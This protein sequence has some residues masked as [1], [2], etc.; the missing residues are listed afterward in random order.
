[1]LTGE[2]NGLSQFL[3]DYPG[4]S[5]TPHCH[6]GIRLRGKF[7]FKATF[8]GYEEIEDTYKLEITVPEK[9]PRELPVV[10]EI[11]EK[12]PRDENK[13][14]HVNS[15]DTLCL[16]S[17]HR[18]LEKIYKSPNLS[19]FT[20]KCLIPYL[21]AVSYKLKHG[22]NFIF[23]ELSHGYSGII[24]DCSDLFGLT[25]HLQVKKCAINLMCL[26]DKNKKINKHKPRI[27]IKLNNGKA[28]YR[29]INKD[30]NC[31]P[32]WTK[33]TLDNKILATI[34][35]VLKTKKGIINARTEQSLAKYIKI[36]IEGIET[37]QKRTQTTQAILMLGVRKR[38]ANKRPCPCGCNNRLGAC[39]LHHKL[40]DFRKMAPASWFKA[41]MANYQG[42]Q[43]IKTISLFP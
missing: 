29:L 21:Y 18:L 2:S 24:D 31:T 41:Q 12:I 17:P 36:I 33:L 23:G 10:K 4:M 5:T 1:M 7:S 20:D 43:G 37:D 40:N 27:D 30:G 16:A 25:S 28:K 32:D 35:N 8:S 15:D 26:R 42:K 34:I 19:S 22:G 14:F 13:S 38:I 6:A 9:F 11:G 39:S 3:D